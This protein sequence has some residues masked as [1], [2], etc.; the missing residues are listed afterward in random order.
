MYSLHALKDEF[1]AG[2]PLYLLFGAFFSGT[3]YKRRGVNEKGHVANYV[4]TEQVS[5]SFF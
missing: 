3:R 4:E 1:S 2:H 5:A